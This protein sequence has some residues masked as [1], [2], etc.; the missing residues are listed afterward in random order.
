MTGPYVVRSMTGYGG[1][2]AERSGWR[3]EVEI[4]G[5]NNR[6]LDVRV[7][8]P[9]EV[10]GAEGDLRRQVQAR[11]AR[12]RIDASVQL[13]SEA[14]AGPRLEIR[15]AVVE[16]YLAAARE[17]KRRHRLRGSLGIDQIVALPGVAQV[18]SSAPVAGEPALLAVQ[19]AFGKALLA[20]EAMGQ[21]EGR[22]L[23]DDLRTRLGEVGDSVGRISEEAA[24]QPEIFAGRL[25][26]RI[27]A[28]GKGHGLDPGRLEQEVALLADRVDVTEELVRLRG[29]LEQ[30]A[31]ILS[32]PEGPVGKSLDFLM[33]E[34]NREANTVS[35]KSESLAICR[36][37]LRIRSLVEAIRE[38]VQNLE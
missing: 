12:G 10:S 3:A 8:L 22:R 26:E 28:L 6:Y 15:L 19:E 34:M 9:Q 23:V 1:G 21:A 20:F 25:R 18:V 30:A 2:A 33:Q 38:Q 31:A 35:S 29:H 36:E 24:R 5:A 32:R 11:V 27:E 14:S 16:E 17:L 13:V 37:A 4:R 7:K